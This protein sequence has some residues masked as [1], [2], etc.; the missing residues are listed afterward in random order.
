[1]TYSYTPH[2]FIKFSEKMNFYERTVNMLASQFE[3]IYVELLH[4]KR[5]VRDL[6]SN[7]VIYLCDHFRKKSTINF[8]KTPSD[9]SETK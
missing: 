5:Q 7:D 8:S 3:N 6:V 9:R 4:Y 1:M 2:N